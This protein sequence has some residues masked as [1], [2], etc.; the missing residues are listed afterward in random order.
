MGPRR[1]GTGGVNVLYTVWDEDVVVPLCNLNGGSRLCYLITTLGEGHQAT[2][3]VDS[4][5]GLKA[6]SLI[7]KQ[8]AE[9]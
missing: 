8:G 3:N 5:N 9:G 1:E 2:G 7:D 6:A 4:A